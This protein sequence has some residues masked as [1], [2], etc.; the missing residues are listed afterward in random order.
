MWEFVMGK[1]LTRRVPLK[2]R[3]APR[4]C[5]GCFRPRK[6]VQFSEKQY[7][8]STTYNHGEYW[9]RRCWDCL[10]RFYHPQLAD[11]EAREKFHRQ[12]MCGT[13][14]CLR[15]ADED[16][17]GCEVNKD[18]IAEWTRM[19]RLKMERKAKSQSIWDND[20]LLPV[21]WEEAAWGEQPENDDL[22]EEG[23][24]LCF[25]MLEFEDDGAFRED[26]V[27][28][29]KSPPTDVDKLKGSSTSNSNLTTMESEVWESGPRADEAL[30]SRDH[31]AVSGVVVAAH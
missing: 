27:R 7:R 11:T 9:R 23:I 24:G 29:S 8:L 25:E 2:G 28:G 19:K 30:F 22:W 26:G 17:R 15:F 12:V 31:G 18:K 13:C 16:C 10:R 20:A 6:K 21:W 5:F 3:D 1:I 4:V 14:R